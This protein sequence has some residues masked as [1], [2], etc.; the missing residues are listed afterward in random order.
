[1]K[2]YGWQ[3]WRTSREFAESFPDERNPHGQTREFCAARSMA[4]VKRIGG[5]RP[6][7]YF[8]LGETGNERE[9]ALALAQPGVIFWRP[10]DCRGEPVAAP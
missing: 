5:G 2:V 3:G 6:S 10:I 8:N 1:V 9:I 7:D 4:E